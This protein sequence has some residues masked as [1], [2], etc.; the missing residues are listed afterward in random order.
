MRYHYEKPPIYLSMYGQRYC[1]DHPVYNHCTLFLVGERG[2]AVIQ[3]RYD[4][5]TK[6]TFWAE[7]DEWLTDP[8]YLHPGRDG[9][10]RPLPHRDHPADHVGAED[11]A[12][13]Q[14]ALG[15]GL[16]P[17]ADLTTSFMRNQLILKGVA[18]YENI[19][20]QA[21]RCGADA[22]RECSDIPG[23]G[24]HGAGIYRDDCSSAVLCKRKLDLLKETAR[25]RAFPFIFALISQLLLRRTMLAK[26]GKGAWT[27]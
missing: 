19:Q 12:P 27:K 20:E 14:A 25:T 3:Q 22:L 2:L 15:D 4:P 6:H 5:E 17:Y 13:T 24:R 1:C 8:L 23:A 26:G 7:V 21:V 11:E 16:R 10:G 9:Y 18:V